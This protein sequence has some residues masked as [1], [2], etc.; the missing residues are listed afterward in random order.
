M[1]RLLEDLFDEYRLRIVSAEGTKT[2]RSEFSSV[3]ETVVVMCFSL[4]LPVHVL[5]VPSGLVYLEIMITP[6]F[7]DVMNSNLL[8]LIQKT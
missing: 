4:M 7:K 8:P 2:H 5:T 1:G 6:R 3:N